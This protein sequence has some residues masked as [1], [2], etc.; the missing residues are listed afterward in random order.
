MENSSDNNFLS[1]L[2]TASN[3]GSVAETIAQDGYSA[4]G[5]YYSKS[6]WK[7]L[8]RTEAEQLIAAGLSIFTVYEDNNTTSAAF[9]SSSGEQQALRALYQAD[10]VIGQ[11]KGTG[12]Y[13]AVDYDASMYDFTHYIRPYLQAVNEVFAGF[14]QPYRVGVYGSGLVC[15]AAKLEGLAS[16]SW[17]SQSTGYH[18]YQQFKD[19]GFWNILQGGPTTISGVSFDQDTLNRSLGSYGGFSK[20]D[21]NPCNASLV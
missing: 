11:P 1:G 8:T 21:S 3:A 17:L 20:L 7:Q 13:F 10:A 14:G 18:G 4:V 2:D 16:L 9:S 6:T 5:R 19:S 12:I 15:A